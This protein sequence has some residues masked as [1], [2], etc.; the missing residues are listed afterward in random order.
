MTAAIDPD[1]Q[2]TCEFVKGEHPNPFT[3]I[4][5]APA[6][7]RYHAMGGGYMRLCAEHGEK[8]RSYCERWDGTAWR[9]I[10]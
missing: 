2:G 1:V 10:E 6:V 9:E 4:C 7:L 8:H 5:K 3:R